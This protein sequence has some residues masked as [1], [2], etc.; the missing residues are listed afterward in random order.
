MSFGSDL[1]SLL[2]VC[3]FWMVV[4]NKIRDVVCPNH[5]STSSDKI[6]LRNGCIDE[7]K[8]GTKQKK[9]S[10]TENEYKMAYDQILSSLRDWMKFTVLKK[11]YW[12]T[13]FRCELLENAQ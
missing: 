5:V 11:S 8:T 9:I 12:T 2:N 10:F 7:W 4:F 6:R 1:S 3:L 13:K